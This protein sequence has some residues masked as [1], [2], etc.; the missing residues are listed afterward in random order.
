M[1]L[2]LFVIFILQTEEKVRGSLITE[3][4]IDKTRDSLPAQTKKTEG[5]RACVRRD[6]PLSRAKSPLICAAHSRCDTLKLLNWIVSSGV[7]IEK[8]FVDHRAH[9]HVAPAFEL[10]GAQSTIDVNEQ[11]SSFSADQRRDSHSDSNGH[12]DIDSNF[13]TQSVTVAVA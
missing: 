4:W 9:G 13:F 10:L 6:S 2:I 7:S 1:L 3:H 8:V 5:I 11:R 12:A